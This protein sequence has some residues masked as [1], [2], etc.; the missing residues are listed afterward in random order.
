VRPAVPVLPL[1]T[2]EKFLEQGVLAIPVLSLSFC[3]KL[4]EEDGLTDTAEPVFNSKIVG[5]GSFATN[6]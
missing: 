1:S 6:C 4:S 5:A 3:E 2:Q